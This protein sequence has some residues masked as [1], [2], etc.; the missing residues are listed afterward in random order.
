LEQ[1]QG[2]GA[3]QNPLARSPGLFRS[4]YFVLAALDGSRPV[5]R[6]QLGFLLNL[7]RGGLAARM[8]IV[9]RDDPMSTAGEATRDRLS[10]DADDLAQRT[11]TEVVVGGVGPAEIDTNEWLREQSLILRLVLSLV[12]FLVLVP[13]VR[14]LTLPLLAALLNL[15]TVSACFGL[16]SLLFDSSLL[17]GPGFVDVSVIPGT[18]IVMF[19][20]AIDYE[21]FV[22]ARMRE[23]Y[24]RTGSP[25]EAITAGLDRTAPVVTGAALIMIGV[26]LAFSVSPF[27]TIRNFGVAQ[28]VGVFIDAFIVRLIVVPAAM[29]RL[30]QW[31]WW[32]PAW[33]DRLLPGG[34][35]AVPGRTAEAS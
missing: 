35:G 14:S 28:A 17:G 8:L 21:V 27:M 12:T 19:G 13:V 30:G 3:G 23:E 18:M 10:E 9:P 29:G 34:S 1:Q 22:F 6:D 20:L 31:S 11:G 25:S 7:D 16:L 4:G 26:F 2:S 15:I 33:L 5:R 24:V 32:M